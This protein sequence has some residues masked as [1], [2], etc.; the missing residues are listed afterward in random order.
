MF[1][2]CRF[3]NR[4]SGIESSMILIL[5]AH[6]PPSLASWVTDLFEISCF[7]AS[8]L[9]LRDATDKEIFDNARLRNAIL[10]TKDND[11][12]ELLS[13]LGSPPKVIWLTC[14]NTSKQRLKEILEAHLLT[15]LQ[16]LGN[17]DLVE[18]T[19]R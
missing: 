7:S 14:G 3:Q 8:Y 1:T 18:I 9:G 6:L 13:R 19:G 12:V 17:S 10:L 16:L 4:P 2:L 15:S 5:D 11:F